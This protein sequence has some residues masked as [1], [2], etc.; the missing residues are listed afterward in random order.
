[1]KLRWFRRFVKLL[2]LVIL[3][4]GFL[5]NLKF[6]SLPILYS[7]ASPFALFSEPVELLEDFLIAKEAPI[8]VLG[9]LLILF[10]IFG[11]AFCGWVCPFGLFQDILN[12][13]RV[14]P[15][16]SLHKIGI[17][18]KFV[19]LI[20]LLL[21]SFL[22]EESFF[23]RF[24]PHGLIEASLPYHLKYG[25]KVNNL[26]V[27]R[28]SF[29]FLLFLLFL[30]IPRFWCRY[31]C[32]TGALAG[33]FNKVSLLT[34]NLDESMCDSCRECV[35][36]CPKAI[37]VLEDLDSI[38]CN[39]CGEC[40]DACPM[41]ALYLSTSKVKIVKKAYEEES[42]ELPEYTP[43]DLED[44]EVEEVFV[45]R[46]GNPKLSYIH[47]GEIPKV[48]KDLKR[49]YDL[50]L[51]D[52]AEESFYKVKKDTLIVNERIYDGELELSEIQELVKKEDEMLKSINII[53]HTSSC[54]V[55]ETR[56]CLKVCDKPVFD[57]S[58]KYDSKTPASISCIACGKCLYVCPYDAISFS[59]GKRKG[60]FKINTEYLRRA[61]PSL[62]RLKP[63]R[64]ILFVKRDSLAVN[65]LLTMIIAISH[66]AKGR[67]SFELINS[68]DCPELVENLKIS[69]IPTVLLEN[70]RTYGMPTE[71]SMV[72][73][74]RRDSE[75]K[76][77]DGI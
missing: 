4:L 75:I 71:A 3:N 68:E 45:E 16:K 51:L 14:E 27:L 72:L 59:Y 35:K 37:E 52:L 57:F 12:I 66:T 39:R 32:P 43:F 73:L 61:F 34:L 70:I 49:V 44:E 19:A 63:E 13:S 31:L 60:E 15:R 42:L 62:E 30:M 36:A 9:L 67:V 58:K 65:K 54:R 18:F 7:P 8:Y 5:Y 46:I 24:S 38:E 41:E 17:H 1:M 76:E 64:L 28:G 48:I 2:S 56:N 40:I 23:A 6:I 69:S 53:F 22:I 50:E 47:K 29:L 33:P 25:I 11:R 21:F 20:S 74:I 55:C 77:G 26:I 10:S